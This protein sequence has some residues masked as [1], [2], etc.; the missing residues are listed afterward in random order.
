MRL[1]FSLIIGCSLAGCAVLERPQPI[2]ALA[3]PMLAPSARPV[4]LGDQ[5]VA[6]HPWARTLAAHVQSAVSRDPAKSVGRGTDVGTLLRAIGAP[7]IASSMLEDY[8]EPH[9]IGPHG[10]S[11]LDWTELESGIRWGLGQAIKSGFGIDAM[12]AVRA[13][14]QGQPL[15]LEQWAVLAPRLAVVRVVRHRRLDRG[16]GLIYE[17]ELV[18][19]EAWRGPGGTMLLRLPEMG[20]S[21][22]RAAYLPPVGARLLL[23]GTRSGYLARALLAGLPPSTD[24]RIVHAL[25]P[26]V[27]V[28]AGV[29]RQ[30]AGMNGFPGM[31]PLDGISLDEAR[32]AVGPVAARVE[33]ALL[34]NPTHGTETLA[35]ISIDGKPL[36]SPLY[37]YFS[38]DPSRPQRKRVTGGYDG[39]NWFSLAAVNGQDGYMSTERGCFDPATGKDVEIPGYMET[40]RGKQPPV[41]IGLDQPDRYAP[42]AVTGNGH[43]LTARRYLR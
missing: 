23:A 21:A 26:P 27:P 11:T 31:P 4:A 12:A 1:L 2:T 3:E 38:I 30:P 28:V 10:I 36:K 19:E 32:S 14:A 17:L 43:R 41:F 6:P 18:V 42:I 24:E 33:A 37:L 15:S 39:C 16:D 7:R 34:R 40:I 5:P 35:V 20:D 29:L 8:D 22:K 13:R 25:L 9:E